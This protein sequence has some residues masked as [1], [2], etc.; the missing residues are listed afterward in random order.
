V[1]ELVVP[2]GWAVLEG[3]EGQ[4]LPG[5]REQLVGQEVQVA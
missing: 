3:P 1:V 5:Q 2:A 4:E